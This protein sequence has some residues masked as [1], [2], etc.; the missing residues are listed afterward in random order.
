MK[1]NLY[2]ILAML[3]LAVFV[4]SPVSAVMGSDYESKLDKVK[5]DYEKQINDAKNAYDKQLEEARA[6]K[7]LRTRRSAPRPFV[8]NTARKRR[9]SRPKSASWIFA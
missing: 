6:R 8:R 2:R 3:L 4:T 9:A 7:S 1:K 5:K